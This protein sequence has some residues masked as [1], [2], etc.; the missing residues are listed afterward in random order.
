[1]T[2]DT[3]YYWAVE[4]DGVLDASFTGQVHSHPVMGQPASFRIAAASC[5]GSAP[6]VPGV[7]TVLA[8]NRISNH[9]VFSTIGDIEPRPLAF[10][11]MGDMHYYDLGSGSHGIAGGASLSNYRE[12]YRD[13]LDQPN[14]HGLYRKIPIDYVWDDH[15]YGPDNSDGTHVGKANAQQAYRERVPH[16]SLAES[17]AIY[18]SFQIG[19]VLFMVSDTRSYRSPNSDTDS[20]SKTMLGADQKLWMSDLLLSSNASL[21]VWVMPSQWMGTSSDTWASFQFEQAEL[22]EMFGS[23]GWAEKMCIIS[24]DIHS[25]AIDTGGNSPGGFPVFQFAS[26]D[27]TPTASVVNQYDTGPSQPGRNQYGTLDITDEGGQVTVTGTGWS[28]TSVWRSHT[29]TVGSEPGP[30]PGPDPGPPPVAVAQIRTRVT[31]LGCRLSDG[32]IIA[33]LPDITGEVSRVLGDITTSGLNLPIPLSGPAALPIG[34]VEQA[35]EP[36]RAMIAAIVNDIPTWAGIVGVSDGGTEAVMSLPVASLEAYLERRIVRDHQFNQVDEAVIAATLVGDAG[37]IAGVGSGI[38]LEID[39]PLTGTLRTREYLLTDRKTV[40]DAL[41]ELMGVIDGPEWTIDLDWTDAT[42]TAIAKIFR[43]RKRI[44]VASPSPGAVFQATANSVFGSR[45]GSEAR[46]R[47]K[48]NY[49]DGH[50]AN[51]VVAY[52]SG[53]GEDQAESS[54]AIASEVLAAGY[55]IYERHFQ[56]SS[57]IITAS[58]L[59]SHATAE[60][61]RRRMGTRTFT[62]EA[63]WDAYPRYGV[64][65]QLG[66]DIAWNLFGHRHPSGVQGQG[67]VIGFKLDMQRQVIVPILREDL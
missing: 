34:L 51:Y 18:H 20:P 28:G 8:S 22:V 30:G 56:P 44:G 38:G 24:G 26:L 14:Q 45:D 63:R 61:G 17:Q 12:S 1:M 67:R 3:G 40:F 25:L 31:W 9:G 62:L 47:Y 4:H 46:Y 57:N 42:K 37:D 2:P 5:A 7:G 27:S 52:S 54:P 15:D 33:E 48:I 13:V 19:R 55:P 66:D 41:Q 43:V 64:D 6:E 58:V 35:T 32:R 53:Q 16:Y 59:N 11:H 36:G 60:L 10:I 29:F 39:A 65:W 23:T 50:G 49:T 21:L